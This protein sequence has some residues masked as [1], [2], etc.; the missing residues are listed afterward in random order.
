VV[1]GAVLIF[2][3]FAAAF[4]I[5]YNRVERYRA[6]AR[7][8]VAFSRDASVLH[9]LQWQMIAQGDVSDESAERI[10]NA[11][12]RFLEARRVV[13][14]DHDAVFSP[15]TDAYEAYVSS[16]DRMVLHLATG[17]LEALQAEGAIAEIAYAQLDD[18]VQRIE[19]DAFANELRNL[20]LVQ[21]GTFGVVLLGILAAVA[22]SFRT[23]TAHLRAEEELLKA[24]VAEAANHSKSQFLANMSHELRTPL[25][26]IIGYS[27]MLADEAD[28]QGLDSSVPELQK[29]HSAGKHLLSLI[30]SILDLSKIE[31]G[32]M[33]L[34]LETFDVGPMVD[35]VVATIK[36][37]A[38]KNRN[39]LDLRCAGELGVMHS[40]MTKVRQVLFNLLSNACKFT[41]NGT[42]SLEASREDVDGRD[43]ID[44]RV[45][46]TGIGITS[47]QIAKLFQDF[48]QVDAS[49]TRKYGG[50]GLGL[51][52][53]R[54][55]CEMMGG[56]ITVESTLDQGSTFRVRIPVGVDAKA[57]DQPAETASGASVSPAAAPP[58]KTVLVIDDDPIV[59]DLMKRSLVKEGF[60][61]ATAANGEEG[62]K[63]AR[64]LRPAAITLDLMMPGMDGWAVM[65]ALKR[66]PDVSNIPVVLVTMTSDTTRGYALG[67]SEF[68]IEPVDGGRLAAVLR[69][70][71]SMGRP[72][73][74]LVV[75]DDAV[76]RAMTVRM[77]KKAGWD[78]DEAENG[79][80]A[81]E[82]LAQRTPQLIVLD[83]MMPEMDGFEFVAEL[84]KTSAWQDIPVVVVT[85]IDLTSS[86]RAR[87][88]GSVGRI[89]R[90]AAHSRN[91]LLLA[92]RE[93]LNASLQMKPAGAA[94]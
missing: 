77:L 78:V 28:D 29:I 8:L 42:I 84:R 63:A 71:T 69:K 66:D 23:I 12:L 90:K 31:A 94:R 93:Q 37:L 44:F 24:R 50:T 60:H 22:M 14:T 52:I 70:H 88:N 18:V 51:A 79:R 92:V 85:A 32:R 89:L 56:A 54:R 55:F 81:L 34:F 72:A 59:Q 30:D 62:L 26:A 3:A 13:G 1:A 40:D 46:D 20:R 36:P 39:A 17:N 11:R 64:T 80:A 15:L 45:R 73:S 19:R 57:G 47:E 58:P 9:S 16:G 87:L 33:E 41:E 2:A 7:Q 74:V 38:E 27:E 91:E 4:L 82:R 86:D 76:M 35:D 61:V 6:L 10:R 68:L 75:E 5:S 21:A 67:A 25:N 48:T 53:S 83:L 43:F 49:T 65:L